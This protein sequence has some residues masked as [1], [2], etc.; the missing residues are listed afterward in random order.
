MKFVPS[1]SYAE[2][3]GLIRQE[4]TTGAV[5]W[6]D[7]LAEGHR[8]LNHRQESHDVFYTQKT[9]LLHFEKF[10]IRFGAPEV[11]DKLPGRFQA[12]VDGEKLS[13]HGRERAGASLRD[14]LETV[15]SRRGWLV[16]PLLRYRQLQRAE[17]LAGYSSETLDMLVFYEQS[18]RQ[19]RRR[20]AWVRETDGSVSRRR[21]R[22]RRGRRPGGG[23]HGPAGSGALRPPRR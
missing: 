6:D 18:A 3:V 19:I 11:N 13:G 9:A 23:A 4:V 20:T 14:L 12:W 21:R 17:R 1:T 2:L 10:L 22:R 5:D 15:G 7:F 8:H 16:R